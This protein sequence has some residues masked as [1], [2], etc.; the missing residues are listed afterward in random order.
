I[1][2][3][4]ILLISRLLQGF[5]AGG[6]FGSSSSLL[7]ESASPLRRAF[8]GSWQQ[9]SAGLGVLLA[10]VIALVLTSSLNDEAMSSWGWRAAFV[11]GGLLGLV[12]LWIRLGMEETKSFQKVQAEGRI[13]RNPLTE[14]LW[15]HPLSSLRVI[16][17]S[18]AGV[19]IYYVWITYMP[20]YA[21]SAIG[22]VTLQTALTAN[23]ISLTYFLILLPFVAILADKIGRKPIMITF[24]GGFVLFSYPAFRLLEGG[25]F[26]TLFLVEII[27]MTLLAGYASLIATVMAEQFPAEVRTTGI[28]FPYAIS[29]AV[30]GGTAPYITTWL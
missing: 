15:K 9:V 17:M 2:A 13:T 22:N 14:V 6:E 29:V 26:W 11:I 4:L 30:F 23:T 10:A 19:L 24:A 20:G 8:A 27:G 16:G 12:A 28:A 7:V 1:F 18:L 3:P 21:S 5:S 25:G